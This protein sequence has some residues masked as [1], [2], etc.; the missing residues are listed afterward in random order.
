MPRP[1]EFETGKALEDVMNIF[2]AKGY[3]GTSLQD[4]EQATG[5]KKQS[6]YRAIGDKRAMYL[7]ALDAYERGEI[8]GA[9]ALLRQDGSARER[10]DRLFRKVISVAVSSGDRRGCFLCN[11]SVDQ[12]PYHPETG[13][14]VAAMMARVMAEFERALTAS[15]PFDA[16]HQA[17]RRTARKL[18]TGYFGLRVMIKAGW[19]ID[20]LLEAKD[21]LLDGI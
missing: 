21:A 5:L 4:I 1:R 11:A 13:R 3:E 2:W 7:G 12:A 8:S 16:D 19:E 14:Q 10:F 15:A 18:V 9:A 17:R 20:A 6:L